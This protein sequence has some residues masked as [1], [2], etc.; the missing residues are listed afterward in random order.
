MT[1]LPLVDHVIHVRPPFGPGGRSAISNPAI[2]EV[3]GHLVLGGAPD[4]DMAVEAAFDAFPGR[5]GTPPHVRARI[6]FRFRDLVE[7]D[8]DRLAAIVTAE[9][10]E[11][12]IDLLLA[13]IADDPDFAHA[14][15][16]A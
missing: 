11:A 13:P 2:G 6:L 8:L 16:H 9:H 12:D 4:I 15:R 10:G 3:G 5:A 7:R 1:G 14:L